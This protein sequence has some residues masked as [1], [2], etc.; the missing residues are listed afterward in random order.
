MVE[1]MGHVR[2]VRLPASKPWRAV[3][4][5]LETGAPDD[6]VVAQSAR[7][8]D[9]SFELLPASEAFRAA[10]GL[11]IEVPLAARENNFAAALNHLDLGVAGPPGLID[12]VVACAMRL[13]DVERQA[14]APSDIGELVR[15]AALTT[16]T[17][18]IEPRLPGL[19][20][21]EPGDV[22]AAAAGFATPS[23]FQQL[24]RSFFARLTSEILSYW[25]GRTLPLQVGEGRRF[26]N[27][28]DRSAFDIALEQYCA[29]AS[30]IVSEFS[31]GWYA[32][33]VLPGGTAYHARL[34]GFG[35]IAARKIVS[36]LQRKH[37]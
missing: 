9:R 1:R 12:L 3:V 16:L 17:A 22:Q 8:A 21:A 19:F 31:S 4:E 25:L 6:D 24:S 26:G 23:G 30:R 13:E 11:L 36:E 15:R 7:A 35:A 37:A 29:E 32:R 2:L 5:L 28:G 34:P 10:L 20:E 14:V 18:N 33:H 27:A